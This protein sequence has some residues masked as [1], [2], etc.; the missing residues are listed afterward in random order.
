LR[1]AAMLGVHLS[2]MPHVH[3]FS[4]WPCICGGCIIYL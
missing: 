1:F 2:S 4:P 3:D